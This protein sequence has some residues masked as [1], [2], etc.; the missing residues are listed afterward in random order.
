[1]VHCD[2]RKSEQVEILKSAVTHYHLLRHIWY[3]KKQWDDA[4]GHNSLHNNLTSQHKLL[5]LF[6]FWTVCSD[7]A[8]PVNRRF[9]FPAQILRHIH[10]NPG[11]QRLNG[12]EGDLE[13]F[14]TETTEMDP[15]ERHDAG[16]RYRR[17]GDR[18]WVALNAGL[19]VI[20]SWGR[21]SPTIRRR[22]LIQNNRL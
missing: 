8:S 19:V 3:Y 4:I 6:F 15:E 21:Q 5:L 13:V 22:L 14:D 1:M 11:R 12:A 16:N 18:C 17:S 7:T 2:R 20:Y 9:F 10:D